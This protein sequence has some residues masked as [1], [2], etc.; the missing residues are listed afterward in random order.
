MSHIEWHTKSH[1][2]SISTQAKRAY[3]SFKA[4]WKPVFW[5]QNP[6]Q[7][8]SAPRY[9]VHGGWFSWLLQFTITTPIWMMRASSDICRSCSWVTHGCSAKQLNIFQQSFLGSTLNVE[10]IVLALGNHPIFPGKLQLS[11]SL[12]RK[13]SRCWC[14]C[15]CIF[16]DA[17]NLE[18]QR[19]CVPSE[20]HFH[21][22]GWCGMQFWFLV[23]SDD[24]SHIL[25]TDLWARPDQQEPHSMIFYSPMALNA[26]L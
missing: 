6:S 12:F 24:G 10:S 9:V 11:F 16:G 22:H 3:N 25:S 26:N 19:K 15:N 18:N 20:E 23:Q 14:Q 7:L 21:M 2:E 5:A 4:A 13:Y 8:C 1:E 17:E